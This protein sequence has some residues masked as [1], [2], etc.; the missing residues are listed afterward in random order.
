MDNARISEAAGIIKKSQHCIALTGAGI[1][2]ESGIPD[3]RGKNG[4][5]TKYNPEEYVHIDGF[6][7]H[8]EKIWDMMSDL[9]SL[10]HDAVPNPAHTALAG[11]E[12]AG[13]LKCLITQNIDNL[14]QDAGSQGVVEFHGNTRDVQCLK[15][16]KKYPLDSF[17]RNH[18]PPVCPVCGVILKPDFVFFGEMIPHDALVRSEHHAECADVVIVVGTSAVVYPAAAIPS[19]AKAHGAV[20]IEINLEPTDLTDRTTDIFLG[21]KAGDILPAVA[22]QVLA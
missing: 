13:V 6:N 22:A 16:K 12:R 5:W 9:L 11:L 2:V 18:T 19:T 14:H 21:G 17:E 20:I 4:L 1:S 15:C 3:F 8:P 10:T 7:R